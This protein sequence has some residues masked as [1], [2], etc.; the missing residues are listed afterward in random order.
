MVG[1]IAFHK[2]I[3]WS[4][5]PTPERDLD[6]R[7]IYIFGVVLENR[8][9]SRFSEL[10]GRSSPLPVLLFLYYQFQAF[11]LLDKTNQPL[12]LRILQTSGMKQAVSGDCQTDAEI[13]SDASVSGMGAY[14]LSRDDDSVRW[15]AESWPEN[16][17]FSPEDS[18]NLNEFYA[19]VS[20]VLTWKHKLKNKK[21]LCYSDNLYTV[22][23]VN[24]GLYTFKRVRQSNCPDA[25]IEK[26]FWALTNTCK[27]SD[28]TL[29]AKHVNRRDNIAADLLSRNNVKLFQTIVPLAKPVKKKVKKLTFCK[30]KD[31]LLSPDKDKKR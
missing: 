20:A 26:L 11:R 2:H 17:Y 15:I 25:K 1:G 10:F 21:L 18:S 8:S 28:I 13:Y 14:F 6:F 16:L 30:P 5:N 3:Y 23:L 19:L 12:K 24:D 22:K 27:H 9:R 7:W 29:V 4:P 31:D